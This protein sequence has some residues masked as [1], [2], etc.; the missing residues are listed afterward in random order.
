MAGSAL[1]DAVAW[2]ARAC[3]R[4][5]S[6]LSVS[7]EFL[8]LQ[9]SVPEARTAAVDGDVGWRTRPP[10]VVACP[11]CG[12]RVRQRQPLDDLECPSC[13]AAV[14]AGEVDGLELVALTC[15]NCGDELDHGDRHPGLVDGPEWASCTGCQYHWEFAH[16]YRV[17]GRGGG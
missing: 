8:A 9:L 6:V 2:L 12:S 10:A 15:P 11:E 5:A 4:V 13:W 1:S 17:A 7:E 3:R 16:G 14:P